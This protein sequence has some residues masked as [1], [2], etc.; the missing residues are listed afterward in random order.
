MSLIILLCNKTITVLTEPVQISTSIKRCLIHGS[1]AM[2]D[3]LFSLF[4]KKYKVAKR[5][6]QNRQ[7]NS[8]R[9]TNTGHKSIKQN[10]NQNQ[11]R[12]TAC[13]KQAHCSRKL[14]QLKL[15]ILRKTWT[16]KWQI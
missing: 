6:S 4:S 16:C 10:P 1:Y 8:T 12:K 15:K 9:R 7:Q 11:L 14:K 13:Q 5:A 3:I 2:L